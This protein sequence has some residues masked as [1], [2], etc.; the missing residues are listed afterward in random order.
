LFEIFG[1]LNS[2]CITV[3]F[4]RAAKIL[5][6]KVVGKGTI[7][8]RPPAVNHSHPTQAQ[9]EEKLDGLRQRNAT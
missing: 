2:T 3:V 5:D 8:F 4:A 6:L 9:Q 7:S 1:E